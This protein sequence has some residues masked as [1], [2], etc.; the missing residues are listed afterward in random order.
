MTESRALYEAKCQMCGGTVQLKISPKDLAEWLQPNSR[1][2]Q[3]IFP[4]LTPAERESIK[5]G[6]CVNCQRALFPPPPL[7]DRGEPVEW[8]NLPTWVKGAADQGDHVLEF[9]KAL[10]W[11]RYEEDGEESFT[12]Y[13]GD[14]YV[15]LFDRE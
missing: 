4:Y 1:H 10:S 9:V 2:V 11:F 12:A 14:E 3:Q 5:S 7:E 8:D 6:L 13:H 15:G